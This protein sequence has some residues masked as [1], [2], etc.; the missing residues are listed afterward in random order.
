MPVLLVRCLLPIGG[1]FVVPE[2][3]R[4]ELRGAVRQIKIAEVA[5]DHFTVM[6]SESASNAIK[7]FLSL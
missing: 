3:I 6:T 1:G 4:D 7:E 5:S 2:A